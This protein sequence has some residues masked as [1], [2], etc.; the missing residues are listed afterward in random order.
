MIVSNA[1]PLIYL[2]KIGKHELLKDVFGNIYISKEVKSE[3]VDK[4]KLLGKKDAYVIE[5]AIKD[6][7]IIVVNAV[8]HATSIPLDAG[9]ESTINLALQKKADF[10]LLDEARARTAAKLMG[11]KPL[12]TAGILLFALKKRKITHEELLSLIEKLVEEGFRLRHEV[13]LEIISRA[14]KYRR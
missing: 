13:Y 11:L 1:T 4:G 6:G 7:W 2:A 8:R 12:G 9:E 5:K 3:V 10:V 14:E